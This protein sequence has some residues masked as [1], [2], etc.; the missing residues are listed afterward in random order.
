MSSTAHPAQSHSR[1]AAIAAILEAIDQIRHAG[2]RPAALGPPRLKVEQRIARDPSRQQA[3]A[4]IRSQRSSPRAL[5]YWSFIGLLAVICIWVASFVWQSVDGNAP[6]ARWTA[7]R[8]PI[9]PVSTEKKQE[10]AGKTVQSND[11]AKTIAPVQPSPP[12]EAAPQREAPPTAAMSP[13]LM[14]WMQTIVRELANLEHG[15]EELRAN[16][17]QLA[18]DNAEHVREM[19]DQTARHDAQLIETLKAAQSQ[20]IRDSVNTFEQLRTNQAKLARDNAEHVK[21]MQDQAARH[22]AQLIET[23]R[24]AQSQMIRDSMN[25]FEQLRTNQE[26]VAIIGEKIKTIQEQMDRFVASEQQ[27][28]HKSLVSP[29]PP[30]VAPTRKPVSPPPARL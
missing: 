29:Q 3:G 26:Q 30:I 25:T 7:E 18:R 6:V 17:A 8:A 2:E 19:Q 22:D 15:I 23:L 21:E 28:H 16:Q 20:M 10:L 13:E 14:Q 24:E 11:E 12:A 1:D 4:A 27:P 9:S 5:A